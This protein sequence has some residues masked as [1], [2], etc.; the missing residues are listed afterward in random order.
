MAEDSLQFIPSAVEGLPSVTEAA[1]FP[2]RLELLSE[3]KWIVIRFRDIARWYSGGWL[4]HSLARLGFRVR[5]WPSVADRDWFHP[6]A[7]RFFRFY[8]TPPVTVYLPDEPQ[9]LGYGDT[10][11]RRVQNVLRQGG[12][13]TF[14]LG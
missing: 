4:Y 10:M 2:D 1:V 13:S 9:E 7:R 5:G 12:F 3:D 14:D 11:F 6:P 8:T